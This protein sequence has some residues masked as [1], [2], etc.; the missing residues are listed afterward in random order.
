MTTP[1][2][3]HIRVTALLNEERAN[4]YSEAFKAALSRIVS[5]ACGMAGAGKLTKRQA[6]DLR[7]LVGGMMGDAERDLPPDA[8]TR[9]RDHA[10]AVM[11][12]L[13]ARL[14]RTP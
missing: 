10:R 4:G 12:D 7:N 5:M 1:S 9:L 8:A 11:E 3:I 6:A 13:L 14:G 2:T